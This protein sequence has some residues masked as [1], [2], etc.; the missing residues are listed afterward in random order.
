MTKRYGQ[1]CP[2]AK[3]AE[4]V[5]ERWTL[6]IVRELLWG[7]ERFNEIQ[8]GLSHISPTLLARRLRELEDAAILYREPAPNGQGSIYRLT[9][10]GAELKPLVELAGEWG[11]QYMSERIDA[12][13]LDAGLLMWDMHRQL[14]VERFPLPLAAVHFHYSDAPSDQR[15]WWL[16]VRRN[17][18]ELCTSEPGRAPDLYLVTSL[19]TMVEVWLGRRCLRAALSADSIRLYGDPALK[20]SID[21]WLGRSTFA[22]EMTA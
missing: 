7:C 20:R 15:H 12:G 10:A 2:V 14:Q 22:P 6:L 3:T 5:C 17:R 9:E 18:V 8:R 19:R 21:Q 4:I 1:F 11:Q 16:L 13:D